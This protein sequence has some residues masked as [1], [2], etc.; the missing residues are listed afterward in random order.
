MLTLHTLNNMKMMNVDDEPAFIWWV[1]YTLKKC[2]RILKA[3]KRRALTRKTE[4]F[5]LELPGSGPKGVRC[6]Y[7]IDAN[8][9]SNHWGDGVEKEVKTVLPALRILG[10]NEPIP[11]AYTCIDLI[12]VFDVKMDLTQKAR[13]CAQGDQTDPPLLITYASV[14]TCES[15]CIGFLLA[16]LYG[17]DILSADIAGVYWNA[18]CAEKIYTVLGPKFGD[19]EGRTAV[20]EKA[21]YGLNLPGYRKNYFRNETTRIPAEPTSLPR[22]ALVLN[23]R[24]TKP[25][26]QHRRTMG[27]S[28]NAKA[29][30]AMTKKSGVS[31]MKTSSGA[32]K[33]VKKQVEIDLQQPKDRDPIDS[34]MVSETQT[35]EKRVIDDNEAQYMADEIEAKQIAEREARRSGHYDSIFQTCWSGG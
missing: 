1:P 7:K 16:L 12:T 4:K 3:V 22:I 29:S 18:P 26:I 35:D 25:T 17:L 13:I 5:G 8:T 19:L 15:I 27:K 20:V 11:P 21:L 32:K 14:V 33:S 30:S 23:L 2:D 31:K 28:I 34:K 6:A 9:G 10:P 24:I